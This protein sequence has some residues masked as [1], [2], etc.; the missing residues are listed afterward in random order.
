MAH[1]VVG[2]LILWTQSQHTLTAE[3]EARFEQKANKEL[4]CF[5]LADVRPLG[6]YSLLI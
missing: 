1:S 2:C 4:F 3:R 5:V 6:P